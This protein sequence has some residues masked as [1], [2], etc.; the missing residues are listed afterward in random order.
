[1]LRKGMLIIS[2]FLSAGV[3]AVS[4]LAQ[5]TNA[6]DPNAA[7][8]TPAPFGGIGFLLVMVAILYFMLI[9]PQQKKLNDHKKM[10]G[11]LRRGDKVVTAGGIIAT[12]NKMEGDDIVLVEIAPDVKVRVAKGS[13][14]SVLT[15]TEPAGKSDSAANEN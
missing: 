6:V 4:A 1:M 2:T 11:E 8:A 15:R 14:A 12:I 5:A 10:L 9:R 3:F 7:G 13:I